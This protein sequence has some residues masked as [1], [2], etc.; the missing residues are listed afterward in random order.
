VRTSVDH[1]DVRHTPHGEKSVDHSVTPRAA[2]T[3][4]LGRSLVPA[5]RHHR[6]RGAARRRRRLPSV[7]GQ[8]R[9]LHPAMLAGK[10]STTVEVGPGLPASSGRWS[11][12]AQPCRQGFDN[13]RGRPR[14]AGKA[15]SMG[16]GRPRL[17]GKAFSMGGGRPGLAGK[18]W[19]RGEGRWR[20]AGKAWPNGGGRWRLAGKALAR[21]RVG[22]GLP[23][24][25]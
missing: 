4:Q 7:I 6:W 3:L 11:R 22:L 12:S 20:L 16:G 21:W 23:A 5:G 14:L 1:S 25:L 8:Q 9:S 15:F 24:R 18:A 19:P 13:R 2:Q 17:A 10:A